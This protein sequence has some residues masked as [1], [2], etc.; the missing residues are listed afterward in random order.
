MKALNKVSHFSKERNL[1]NIV[2]ALNFL[3]VFK[4]I[5][6]IYSSNFNLTQSSL[7]LLLS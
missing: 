6:E 7:T 5:L 4:D 3:L 2:R 1:D